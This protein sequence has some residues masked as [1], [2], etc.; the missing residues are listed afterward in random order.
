MSHGYIYKTTNLVN[1]R[2]YIGQRKGEFCSTYFGSGIV[3]KRAVKQYK[4]KAFKVEYVV[5]ASSRSELDWLEKHLIAE[6]RESGYRD[7]L[8]NISSGGTGGRD[9]GFTSPTK[10]LKR[11]GFS[12][13]AEGKQ[14]IIDANTGRVKS[15]RERRAL[16]LALKGKPKSE[17]AKQRMKE[18]HAD[19]KDSKH[20]QWNP[21][22][23]YHK[24]NIFYCVD[25]GAVISRLR[26]RCITCRNRENN[27]TRW[28]K[29]K[30]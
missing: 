18:R 10:G 24:G 25:C 5:S 16:S 13:S 26:R 1:G 29:R 27:R 22:A 12:H 30:S 4:S 8:Y 28:A 9:K 17:S 7:K 3:I 23:K 20:P 19:V 15:E 21:A 2:F 6:Y 11:L 14:R